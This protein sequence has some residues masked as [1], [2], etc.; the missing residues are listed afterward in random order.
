MNKL[1]E[2]AICRETDR[3]YVLTEKQ[4]YDTIFSDEGIGEHCFWTPIYIKGG[5]Y[6]ESYYVERK[7][8]DYEYVPNIKL[9]SILYGVNYG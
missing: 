1:L 6:R 3:I 4:I 8:A 2:Y 7:I 9:I 5:R